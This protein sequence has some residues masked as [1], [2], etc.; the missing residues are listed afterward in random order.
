MYVAT[1]GNTTISGTSPT[2]YVLQFVG[3][4]YNYNITSAGNSHGHQ[5][6]EY[7]RIAGV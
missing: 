3:E 1:G 2:F 4:G 7:I 6:P 5:F